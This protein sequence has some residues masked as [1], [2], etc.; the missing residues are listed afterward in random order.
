MK[1]EARSFALQAL[2]QWHMA[3][4]PLND[5]E[6]QFRVENDMSG[7]DLKLFS[8]LL[9]GVPSKTTELDEAVK[10]YLDRKQDELDPIEL[11]VLR[12]GTFE[13]AE[14]IDVPYKVAINEAVNLAKTFGAT[15][16]HKYVNGVLDRVARDLRK[17][18]TG[19]KG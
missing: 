2:Y 8:A 1:R 18:E 13:L 16:S 5:I 19:A 17:A 10:P 4:N 11:T 9:H 6:A 3:G 15:D 7:T 12:M 14:M